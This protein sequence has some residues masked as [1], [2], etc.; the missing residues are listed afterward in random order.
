M[1][2]VSMQAEEYFFGG[3]PFE[4]LPSNGVSGEIISFSTN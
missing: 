3:N 1:G 2:S 4:S